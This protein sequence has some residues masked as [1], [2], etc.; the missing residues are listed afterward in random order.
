MLE[1]PLFTSTSKR[2]GYLR[3]VLLALLLPVLW[4]FW[5]L[6]RLRLDTELID[7]IK[8]GDTKAALYCLQAGADPNTRDPYEEQSVEEQSVHGLEAFR[9]WLKQFTDRQPPRF[10]NP[11]L[12]TL[13]VDQTDPDR[14]RQENLEIARA[15]LDHGADINARD[16]D[17][18]TPILCALHL[19][20]DRTAQLLLDRGADI[21]LRGK[22]GYNT[23]MAARGEFTEKLIQRGGDIHAV[24]TEGWTPLHSV[25]MAADLPAIRSLLAHGAE[26]N[27][28][29]QDNSTPLIYAALSRRPDSLEAMKL[30]CA[31]GADVRAKTS[32]GITVLMRAVQSGNVEKV[33][34]VLKQGVDINAK[35]QSGRTVL[36][37]TPDGR[38]A[39]MVETLVDYGADVN[40][41]DNHGH[42]ALSETERYHYDAEFQLIQ[43]ARAKAPRAAVQPTSSDLQPLGLPAGSR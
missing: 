9:G 8:I 22:D 27:A 38:S 17:G 5:K 2:R 19:K 15:L 25:S 20:W 41:Q 37:M 13:F 21:H 16:V 42:T 1:K 31:H 36:M 6:Q 10:H 30:L 11:A 7:A 29:A 24:S 14:T 32:Y 40:A 28:H 23:L 43:E 3:I 33:K 39:E 35:M 12:I 4:G 18:A 34:F 26:V